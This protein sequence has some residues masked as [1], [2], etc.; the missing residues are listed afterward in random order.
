M[1]IHIFN[2]AA[3]LFVGNAIPVLHVSRVA[4]TINLYISVEIIRITSVNKE[5]NLLAKYFLI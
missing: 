4:R 2:K 1:H 3:I 5:K